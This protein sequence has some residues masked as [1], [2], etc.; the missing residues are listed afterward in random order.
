MRLLGRLSLVKGINPR[1][2][3]LNATD[4]AERHFNLLFSARL[5]RAARLKFNDL[6]S[7]QVRLIAAQQAA[8]AE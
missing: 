1:G 2:L 7:A 4:P 5:Q 6:K 3:N 8:C